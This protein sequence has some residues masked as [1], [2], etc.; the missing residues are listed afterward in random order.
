MAA[1]PHSLVAPYALH[2]LDD[3][4]ERGFE[5]HLAVCERCRE[6]LASLAETAMA[7]A[8]GVTSPAPPERLRG[9]ILAAA[10]AEQR[11]SAIPTTSTVRFSERVVTST[12]S[13]AWTS[14]DGFTRTPLT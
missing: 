13:P 9:Q 3:E 7:L 5:E 8:F 11:L 10:A 2:A 12:L 6:E 14:C 1:G 4:E